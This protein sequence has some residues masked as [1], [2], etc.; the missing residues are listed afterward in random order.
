MIYIGIDPSIN[1]TGI[2]IFK[3]NKCYFYYHNTQ[4]VAK[5][6][7]ITKDGFLFNFETPK[8]YISDDIVFVGNE[9]YKNTLKYDA[10]SDAI[11]DIIK[12]QIKDEDFMICTIEGYAYRVTG[13][14]FDLAELSGMIKMKIA[15]LPINKKLITIKPPDVKKFATGKGNSKKEVMLKTF[16]E[17]DT[18]ETNMLLDTFDI[19]N[20]EYV[21]NCKSPIEDIV[22]SYF[23]MKKGMLIG[24]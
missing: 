7:K 1:C 16:R 18:I 4:K 6:R 21:K 3:N 15:K 5:C 10:I 19:N 17:I 11:V 8:N 20:N 22:D 13:R 14:V 9:D 24:R 2:S 23:I 12:E